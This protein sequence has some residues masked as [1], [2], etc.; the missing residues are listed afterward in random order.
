MPC[1]VSFLSSRFFI[2]LAIAA[3]TTF[4]WWRESKNCVFVTKKLKEKCLQTNYL[5]IDCYWTVKIDDFGFS[6]LLVVECTS[7]KY[8]AECCS[9]KVPLQSQH[10][11]LKLKNDCNVMKSNHFWLGI[12][13]LFKSLSLRL[14]NNGSVNTPFPISADKPN[15]QLWYCWDLTYPSELFKIVFDIF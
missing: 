5:G 4:S 7:E 13:D 12:L 8:V 11:V 10:L 9:T 2:W 14:F 6:F 15:F 3:T 1:S